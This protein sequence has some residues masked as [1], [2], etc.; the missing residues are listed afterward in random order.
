MHQPKKAEKKFF[1][2]ITKMSIHDFVQVIPPP[3]FVHFTALL[4]LGKQG[5]MHTRQIILIY[6]A[7]MC[8]EACLS[9]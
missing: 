4:A 9:T 5:S 1:H 2:K 8:S 3:K 7:R 6:M